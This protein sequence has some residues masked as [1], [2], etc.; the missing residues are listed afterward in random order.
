VPQHVVV[1]LTNITQH[2]VKNDFWATQILLLLRFALVTNGL[3]TEKNMQ[4]FQVDL[5]NVFWYFMNPMNLSH[6]S[7]TLPL[8]S[9]NR[10][11]FRACLRTCLESLPLSMIGFF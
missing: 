3:E 1:I 7:E 6:Y 8:R 5:G 9:L 11:S 2:I 4:F 10:E